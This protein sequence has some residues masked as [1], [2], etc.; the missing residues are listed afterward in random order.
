[1]QIVHCETLPESSLF[2]AKTSLVIYHVSFTGI[3][4]R[5]LD[6]FFEPFGFFK[7][8]I[9]TFTLTQPFTCHM[10]HTHTHSTAAL[11]VTLTLTYTFSTY[12]TLSHTQ[13]H[14]RTDWA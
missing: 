14:K 4:E 2:P 1:M 12:K 10:P 9:Y 8:P 6:S 5:T 13:T 7:F 3:M 11:A